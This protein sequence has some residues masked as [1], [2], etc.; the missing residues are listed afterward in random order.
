M[1]NYH[2][3]KPVARYQAVCQLLVHRR[4]VPEYLRTALERLGCHW[5]ES[6]YDGRRKTIPIK[7]S[8]ANVDAD[9]PD[10]QRTDRPRA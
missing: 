3:G 5:F 6:W 10:Q 2:R 9:E 1:I 7:R 4:A 8:V